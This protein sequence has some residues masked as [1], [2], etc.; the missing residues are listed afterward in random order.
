M[1]Y[2]N[3]SLITYTNISPNKTS[4]RNHTIDTISIHCMVAQWTAKTACDYFSKSSVQASCNYA[5]GKDGSIGLCVKESDRSWCTSSSSND[6][7]AITIEVA[8]DSTHPYTVT[9]AAM[10]SLI[11]LLTDICKRNNIKKLLWKGDKSLIGQVAKQNMTVHRWFANKACPGDYLYNKHSYIA[12]EVNMRLGDGVLCW[13]CEGDDVKELQTLLVKAGYSVGSYGA[14]GDF[15]DGTETAVKKFQKDKGLE[16]DG[17]VG[18]ATWAALRGAS[19]KE[20]ASTSTSTST[21][22]S[23]STSE[24]YRIRKSWSDVKSQIGAYSKLESAVSQC[25]DGY[26]VFDNAGKVV[27]DPSAKEEAEVYRVRKSWDDAKSQLGAYKS[28]TG[29]KTVCKEGYKVFNSKGEVVY[30]P[31][32]AYKVKVAVD[33]LKIYKGAGTNYNVVGSI[34]DKG[35]Y[36]I[37]DETTGSGNA[38]KWGLLKS[39]AKNK[40]GWISLDSVKK[41]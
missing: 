1:A 38:T 2:T 16:V 13:G 20:D 25:K 9:D 31:F 28:L 36:T 32:E 39:Y 18:N 37:V 14:D 12:E 15:G 29:A 27:Y 40:D 4:P 7:R 22:A 30:A 35:V 41:M 33:E 21:P 3:S 8:S 10:K 24:L 34:K 19:T 26:K 5:V 11:N 6:N 23:T 17:V